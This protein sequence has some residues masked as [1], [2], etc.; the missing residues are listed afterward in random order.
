[1]INPK[2]NFTL[3]AL[4]GRMVAVGGFHGMTVSAEVEM[5]DP[6]FEV[7]TLV[8]RLPEGMLGMTSVMVDREKLSWEAQ[9]LFRYDKRD[10]LMAENIE[11][12][13]E[14]EMNVKKGKKYA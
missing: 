5:F 3:T 10:M 4:E 14:G 8:E 11:E 2:S 9:E 12:E 7:W 6:E 1:M 13:E